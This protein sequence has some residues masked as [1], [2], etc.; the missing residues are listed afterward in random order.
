MPD[1]FTPTTIAEIRAPDGKYLLWDAPNSRRTK[2]PGCGTALEA[3]AGV[4]FK[5]ARYGPRRSGW[6]CRACVAD[7]LEAVKGWAFNSYLELLFPWERHLAKSARPGVT[8]AAAYRAGGRKGLFDKV[9]ELR[10]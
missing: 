3:G 4:R 5:K 10:A 7:A 9:M 6:C 2:C 8:L 1:L